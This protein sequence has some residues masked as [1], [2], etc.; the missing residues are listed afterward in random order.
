[1]IGVL[2]GVA[3]RFAMAT[4]TYA[5]IIQKVT[6][7]AFVVSAGSA[8]WL[9]LEQA[10]F[11]PE[12]PVNDWLFGISTFIWTM[13]LSSLAVSNN[14]KS[15]VTPLRGTRDGQLLTG[16]Q[17]N[18]RVVNGSTRPGFSSPAAP[19]YADSLPVKNRSIAAEGRIASNTKLVRV[20]DGPSPATST[21][22]WVTTASEI[23]GR[24]A[25]EIQKRLA[26]DFLPTHVADVEGQIGQP[27]RASIA[28][29]ING[30]P[31][32]GLQIELLNR[33][34]QLTNSRPLLTFP[35]N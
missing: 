5:P 24:S 9:T 1:M 14:V 19:R 23:E 33:N 13:G 27:A 30:Q 7:A 29:G 31:G 6:I 10:E 18:D 28:S 21:S 32:G 4:V 17:A 16:P 34:Y 26:L 8:I 15:V 12:T 22:R 3:F 35:A 11:V 25:Q 20:S 2:Q